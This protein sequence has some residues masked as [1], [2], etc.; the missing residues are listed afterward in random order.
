M[1]VAI[2]PASSTTGPRGSA[3]LV[4]RDEHYGT[5]H[6]RNPWFVDV[7]MAHEGPRFT[8]RGA[9]ESIFLGEVVWLRLSAT[10][11]AAALAAQQDTLTHI[12]NTG[13]SRISVDLVVN[14]ETYST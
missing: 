11:S 5:I 4:L 6:R 1:G 3:Q 14:D 8:R 10:V 2:I 7:Y 9:A 12:F 13:T